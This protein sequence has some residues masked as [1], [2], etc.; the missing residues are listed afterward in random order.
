MEESTLTLSLPVGDGSPHLQQLTLVE[1][2]KQWI[3]KLYV[4][5]QM[6]SSFP[7]ENFWRRW[8]ASAKV[9]CWAV[10]SP[11]PLVLLSCRNSACSLARWFWM[12]LIELV[13]LYFA[14]LPPPLETFTLQALQTVELVGVASTICWS[15]NFSDPQPSHFSNIGANI[16]S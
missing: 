11:A 16:Q 14:V 7:S 6:R 10:L 8:S 2:L 15:V 1:H 12:C 9:R 4:L 3:L 5:L 13:V